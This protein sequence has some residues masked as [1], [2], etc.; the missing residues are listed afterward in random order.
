MKA[1][2]DPSLDNSAVALTESPL[3]PVSWKQK[4]ERLQTEAHVF[5]CVFTHRR[6][7]WYAR[8]V[9]I[10]AVGYV[11]SPIQLIPSFIPVI[12]FMDDIVVL[13]LGAKLLRRLT[14][15]DVL[16]E[17]RELARVAEIRRKEKSP[18]RRES[19]PRSE[20]CE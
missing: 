2:V 13:S 10:C 15:P 4:A 3:Q 11:I 16:A 7:R 18:V 20:C 1:C 17:C 14:P 8:L 6:T 9:A 12:G 5:Y 19:L